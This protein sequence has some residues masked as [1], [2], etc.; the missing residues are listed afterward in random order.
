MRSLFRLALLPGESPQRSS[1]LQV[2]YSPAH[3][4]ALVADHLM[5]HVS[6]FVGETRNEVEKPQK[7]APESATMGGPEQSAGA[8]T[9]PVDAE[10]LCGDDHTL[11]NA[12]DRFGTEEPAFP[13]PS[14]CAAVKTEPLSH[15]PVREQTDSTVP[16]GQ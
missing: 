15:H 3:T 8:E 7:V 10:L 4:D 6:K 9:D 12:S 2:D 16:T 5:R 1:G 14:S 13:N 11:G